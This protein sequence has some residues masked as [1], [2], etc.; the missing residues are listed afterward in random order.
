MYFERAKNT[1]VNQMR[2]P[3]AAIKKQLRN[4]KY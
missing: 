3:L 4:S 2:F 1:E